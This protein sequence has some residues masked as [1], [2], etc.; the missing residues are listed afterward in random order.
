[1]LARQQ[2]APVAIATPA[3]HTSGRC[4]LRA[5]SSSGSR[6][7]INGS[8]PLP[9][10]RPSSKQAPRLLVRLVNHVYVSGMASASLHQA[11]GA[12]GQKMSCTLGTSLRPAVRSAYARVLRI[13]DRLWSLHLCARSDESFR[14]WRVQFSKRASGLRRSSVSPF[15]GLWG[16]SATRFQRLQNRLAGAPVATPTCSKNHSSHVML[17]SPG[18]GSGCSPGVLPSPC[19]LC[20][21]HGQHLQQDSPFNATVCRRS[22]LRIRVPVSVTEEVY[23]DKTG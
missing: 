9:S 19:P 22:V 23:F 8:R 1:M 15:T 6:R 21:G 18:S 11:L 16:Q 5:L 4:V 13:P 17:S 14:G 10:S 12:M 20:A 7:G 2:V 3:N